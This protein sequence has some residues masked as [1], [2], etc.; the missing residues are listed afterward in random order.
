MSTIERSVTINYDQELY[1]IH[2][3]EGGYSCLGFDVCLERVH[4]VSLELI[5]RGLLPSDYD[6][7]GVKVHRGTM[8]A[9]DTLM[10]LQDV[11]RANVE[12]TGEAAICGLSPQLVGLEGHRVEVV[13]PDGMT[14]R[15][16]VGKS[17]GWMPRHLEIKRRD[18]TGGTAAMSEYQ[19]V[20]DLGPVR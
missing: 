17:T 10:N 3:P 4:Q 9:Y 7:E 16:I 20:R 19:S 11:L 6:L 8:A 18:S 12:E 14:Y 13:D 15:F 2:L 1:V 5:M